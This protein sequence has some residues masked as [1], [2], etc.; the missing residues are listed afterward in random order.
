VHSCIMTAT[1]DM[2]ATQN[3]NATDASGMPTLHHWVA[4]AQYSDVEAAVGAANGWSASRSP[5]RSR[6]PSLT[7][8][9]GSRAGEDLCRRPQ[10]QRRPTCGGH[11][12]TV[13]ERRK[14]CSGGRALLLRTG[15]T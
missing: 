14:R 15:K 1:T 2:D 6:C 9:K 13:N 10:C 7:P 8:A 4:G 11:A 12:V 3:A 5:R